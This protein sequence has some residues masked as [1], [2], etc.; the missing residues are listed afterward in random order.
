MKYKYKK[1]RIIASKKNKYNA[2]QRFD[3]DESKNMNKLC[4]NKA[5]LWTI[6][7]TIIHL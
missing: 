1:G 4:M 7:E 6:R 2:L 5:R 3:T